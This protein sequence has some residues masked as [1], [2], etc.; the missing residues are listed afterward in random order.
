MFETA[1]LRRLVH[2]LIRIGTVRDVEGP[3]ARVRV[4]ENLTTWLPWCTTRAGGDA[5]WDSISSGEQVLVLCPSGDLAQ[6]VICFSLYQTAHPAPDDRPG[7]YLRTFSD[8]TRL[9]YDKDGHVL[10]AALCPGGTANIAA[11]GGTVWSGPVTFRDA[12]H[13]DDSITAGGDLTAAGQV[14]DGV[15]AMRDMRDIYDGHGHTPG[16]SSPPTAKMG[17]A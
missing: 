17:G 9:S 15:S 2:N 3:R 8:G 11:P 10:K 6:A 13:C 1:E 5:V 12:V 7:L 16:A 14:S 4:G